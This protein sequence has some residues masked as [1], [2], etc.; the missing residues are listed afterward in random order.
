M[1]YRMMLLVTVL[2][3]SSL[4]I[5]VST[6]AQG[7]FNWRGGQGWGSGNP[8]GRI[9][10]VRTVETLEGEVVAV[11]RF[12]PEMAPGVHLVLR[13]GSETISVHLG[14]AWYIENQ[15]GR[16]ESGDGVTI[17]GSRVEF[18]GSLVLI[19]ARVI[20]GEET[21]VLRDQNGIPIWSGWR[22]RGARRRRP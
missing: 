4:A 1:K 13:A 21:L 19:A 2:A 7:R 6:H 11:E 20:R 12:G 5:P 16:I 9:Y 10:D 22:G 8:Y 15:E 3:T 18:E 14:P 17:E